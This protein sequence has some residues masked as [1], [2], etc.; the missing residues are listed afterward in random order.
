MRFEVWTSLVLDQLLAVCFKYFPVGLK[1]QSS[2]H[3][4]I[5]DS[6][7]AIQLYYKYMELQVHGMDHVQEEL[8]R[9]YE[10]G[11]QRNWRIPD[12][13]EDLLYLGNTGLDLCLA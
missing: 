11:Q 6:T 3:D 1:I 8:E 5:E 4:S 2:N 13:D 10:T 7:A 12:D 9:L